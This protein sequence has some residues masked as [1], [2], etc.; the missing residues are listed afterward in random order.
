MNGMILCLAGRSPYH[1]SCIRQYRV[2]YA[3]FF[4]IFS[5][6]RIPGSDL[7]CV[8]LGFLIE[9]DF[10]ISDFVQK[11]EEI[12]LKLCKVIK[13]CFVD[14]SPTLS[15]FN[16]TLRIVTTYSLFNEGLCYRRNQNEASEKNPT[17]L[18]MIQYSEGVF[19]VYSTK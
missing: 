7:R 3:I 5:A 8:Q 12:P 6:C 15:L 10:K 4:S 11:N 1:S 9:I 19:Q 14:E 16:V 17:K 18:K 13:E 2:S